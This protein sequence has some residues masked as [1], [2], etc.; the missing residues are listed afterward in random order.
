MFVSIIGRKKASESK[1]TTLTQAQRIGTIYLHAGIAKHMIIIPGKRCYPLV[2]S[3]KCHRKLTMRPER[4]VPHMCHNVCCSHDIWYGVS[5]VFINTL[6]NKFC[7]LRGQE[8][9]LIREGR[10]KKPCHHSQYQ[11]NEAFD[12][13]Q[14]HDASAVLS[15]TSRNTIFNTPTKIH[16]QPASF[17]LS[18][19]R[20]QPYARIG[21]IAAAIKVIKVNAAML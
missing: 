6:K 4:P 5:S 8:I 7:L 11:G 18:S 16:L 3:T 9:V 2:I 10:D 12:D 1:G 17:P 21:P 19:R 14:Q 13:L 20:A 15:Q